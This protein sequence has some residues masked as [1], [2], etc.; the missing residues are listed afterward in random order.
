MKVT[1]QALQNYNTGREI[2]IM[3]VCGTHTREFF[4]TGYSPMD[5][6]KIA[7]ARST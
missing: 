2:R 1:P 7:A 3:E 4:R 5:A 6:L